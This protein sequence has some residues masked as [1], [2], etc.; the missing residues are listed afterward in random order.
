MFKPEVRKPGLQ[1]WHPLTQGPMAFLSQGRGTGGNKWPGEKRTGT[2]GSSSWHLSAQG[3]QGPSACPLSS[4]TAQGGEGRLWHPLCSW[5]NDPQGERVSSHPQHL[6][7]KKVLLAPTHPAHILLHTPPQN[8][9][10]VQPQEQCAC[11][12]LAPPQLP[13]PPMLPPQCLG[14][15]FNSADI[16]VCLSLAYPSP[17]HHRAVIQGSHNAEVRRELYEQNPL[18]IAFFTQFE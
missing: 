14:R 6:N 15:L 12:L 10:P 2:A 9:Y 17:Q 1:L 11:P 5:K 3:S 18:D 7:L 8:L 16:F 4:P 13:V